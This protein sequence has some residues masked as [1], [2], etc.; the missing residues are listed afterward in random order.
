[1]NPKH[2]VTY[3]VAPAF[4]Y[5]AFV[6]YFISGMCVLGSLGSDPGFLVM[7]VIMF[8]L[9]YNSWLFAKDMKELK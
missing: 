2:L 7:G 5:L 9:G 1:M 8:V 6:L 4:F 3:F